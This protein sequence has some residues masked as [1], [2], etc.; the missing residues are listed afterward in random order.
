MASEIT[1]SM[2]W[3]KILTLAGSIVGSVVTAAVVSVWAIGSF[4]LGS[5]DHNI[6]QLQDQFALVM[7][8][9]GD[10]QGAL[11]G[12]RADLIKDISETRVIVAS[13]DGKLDTLNYKMSDMIEG[14]KVMRADIGA[15]REKK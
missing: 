9:N 3:T 1:I 12:A 5:M 10:L 2:S 8:Q 14:I 6:S 11:G 15:L 7:K 13:L 4:W